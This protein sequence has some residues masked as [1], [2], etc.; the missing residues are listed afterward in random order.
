MPNITLSLNTEDARKIAFD[1]V[2]DTMIGM[3]QYINETDLSHY[4]FILYEFGNLLQ[5]E[6]AKINFDKSWP[7]DIKWDDIL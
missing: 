6:E 1:I 7:R 5:V 2:L 4:K 3:K